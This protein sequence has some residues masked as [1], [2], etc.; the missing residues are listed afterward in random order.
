[1]SRRFST[2]ELK[3]FTKGSF[4]EKTISTPMAQPK[5]FTKSSFHEKTVSTPMAQ[6]QEVQPCYFQI[7]RNN[8]ATFINTTTKPCRRCSPCL[9]GRYCTLCRAWLYEFPGLPSAHRSEI[10]STCLVKDTGK[11]KPVEC[12]GCHYI[13]TAKGIIKYAVCWYC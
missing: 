12:V 9:A 3:T 8:S 11:S 1:M 4:H 6:L 2:T 5:T 13:I 10:C 7:S